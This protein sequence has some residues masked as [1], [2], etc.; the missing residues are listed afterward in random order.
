MNEGFCNRDMYENIH[1]RTHFLSFSIAD[2]LEQ[3]SCCILGRIR[4]PEQ[5]FQLTLKHP[6]V[7]FF[8]PIQFLNSFADILTTIPG[9]FLT[10]LYICKPILLT[11]QPSILQKI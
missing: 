8:V 11:L 6:P 2:K 10:L 9:Q 4:L 7:T 5:S 3:C 1:V